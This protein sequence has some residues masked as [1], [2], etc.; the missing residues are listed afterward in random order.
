[1]IGY[2]WGYWNYPTPPWVWPPS[3]VDLYPQPFNSYSEG[4]CRNFSVLDQ[5]LA[6][7][8]DLR[9]NIIT[10]LYDNPQI[11]RSDKERIMV[12]VQDKVARL[13]GTVR[14]RQ[15][16]LQA[17]LDALGAA[18]IADVHNEIKLKELT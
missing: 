10:S 5:R 12:E 7:D 16:K 3:S 9:E 13:S 2:R 6:D 15:S 14:Y 8:E 1:M 18:G 4:T 11:P 17:Y